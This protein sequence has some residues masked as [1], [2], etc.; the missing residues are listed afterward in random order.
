MVSGYKP[1]QVPN[2]KPRA[3]AKIEYKKG[4][5]RQFNQSIN[6]SIMIPKT[7]PEYHQ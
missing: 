5:E 6:Q 4:Q 3:N 2:P 7:P 1:T